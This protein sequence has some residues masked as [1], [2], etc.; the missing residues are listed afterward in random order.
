MRWQLHTRAPV[1]AAGLAAALQL[2]KNG[3][4]E[5]NPIATPELERIDAALAASSDQTR[6][7]LEMMRRDHIAEH[8]HPDTPRLAAAMQAAV[9]AAVRLAEHFDE[10]VHA[11]ISGD[12]EA[13]TCAVS[14][15]AQRG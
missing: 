10:P 8:V 6:S 1:G 5:R 3:F 9:E 12:L 14:V 11:S 15:A 7:A 2:E 4:L 13:G